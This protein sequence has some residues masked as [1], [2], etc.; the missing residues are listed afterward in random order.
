[1]NWASKSCIDCAPCVALVEQGFKAAK[2][3]GMKKGDR[4]VVVLPDSTRNYMTKFLSDEWMAEGG[5]D[6]DA[7]PLTWRFSGALRE[8]G[9]G[10][11]WE[12]GFGLHLHL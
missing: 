3:A 8:T 5:V 7:R 10:R 4:V 2:Q 1:M 12:A 9:A 11:L 6:L